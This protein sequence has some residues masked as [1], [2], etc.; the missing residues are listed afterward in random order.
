MDAGA[1]HLYIHIFICQNF[2]HLQSAN[3]FY[4]KISGCHSGYICFP[5]KHDVKF[6]ST[7]ISTKNV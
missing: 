5:V 7:E 2:K 4:T 3:Y 6:E 1:L